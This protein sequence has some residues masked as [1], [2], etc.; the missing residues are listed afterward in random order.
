[1]RMNPANGDRYVIFG[2]YDSTTGYLKI[3]P[4][5][6]FL[7]NSGLP[8]TFNTNNNSGNIESVNNRY[9]NTTL[10]I[11][12][13]GNV[14]AASSN[15][16]AAATSGLN[17]FSRPATPTTS[18]YLSAHATT[19]TSKR[20]IQQ[21][22]GDADRF[23][24]PRLT[25]Q[26]TNT[27]GS[28]S[29]TNPA[30][31]FMSHF[32]NTG[33]N[34]PLL[35]Y[36][37]NVGAAGTNMG[38]SFGTADNA[39]A[40][41]YGG[42]TIVADST[43]AK[44]KGGTYSAAGALSNG[45]PVIAWYDE[46]NECLWISH[47]DRIPADAGTANYY[48]TNNVSFPFPNATATNA[49]NTTM[50][51]NNAVK[52]HNLAGTHV[53][54]VID[55]LNNI[56]LAYYDTVNGGLHYA[57]IPP[58]SASVTKL[59][60]GSTTTVTS[61]LPDIANI[62]KAK[63]DTFLAAGTKIMLNVRNENGR[64]VPYISYF[65]ASFAAT[66]N[67]IRV[68]WRKDFTSADFNG[69]DSNDMFTGKWEVMTVPVETVPVSD[70]FICNGVPGTATAWASNLPSALTGTSSTLKYT[71]INNSILVG[72]L[73]S[74]WYEGAALKYDIRTSPGQ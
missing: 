35:F 43:Q 39:S 50:W 10:A 74:K 67:S 38:G 5:N 32:V 33:N 53:D 28:S 47:G 17:F 18:T 41:I 68:A 61:T 66:K 26:I 49:A 21:I 73:T 31:V 1:M 55:E 72:Y 44:A 71:G 64:I 11:D 19:N 46:T 42:A 20:R 40:G 27:S 7:S 22:N 13:N 54:M 57:L 24:I 29:N 12:G 2:K 9:L 63:V 15:Q 23:K 65:H 45:L 8:N 25:T 60:G 51:Q 48:N 14:Y 36:Y 6:S 4:N 52:I 34:T 58:K 69:T 16:T 59:N 30:R 3:I 37:G 62:K 70:E 56:H